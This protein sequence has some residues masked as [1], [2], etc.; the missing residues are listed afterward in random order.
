[1]CGQCWFVF[2]FFPIQ[3]VIRGNP[4]SVSLLSAIREIVFYQLNASKLAV[5][6]SGS[7]NALQLVDIFS[8]L[9][10]GCVF[11]ICTHTK[12]W[13]FEKNTSKARMA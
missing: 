7:Y 1:M 3:N 5:K 6:S 11:P 9:H 12:Q 10:S 4:V 2:F 13:K 8:K